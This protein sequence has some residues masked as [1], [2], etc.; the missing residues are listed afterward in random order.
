M[1]TGL[2]GKT[3]LITGASRNMGRL[4]AIEFA[5]E[6]ANL[7]LC[8]STKMKELAEVAEEARGLGAKVVAERCDVASEGDV[9]SFVDRTRKELG[10]V[11]V[12]INNAVNRGAEGSFA[13][14]PGVAGWHVARDRAGRG[15]FSV[16]AKGRASQA[17]RRVGLRERGRRARINHLLGC[18][19]Q[20]VTR[21]VFGL[22]LRQR[23]THE[24]GRIEVG[25][26]HGWQRQRRCARLAA[27]YV[28]TIGRE[29]RATE[30]LSRRREGTKGG[31]GRARTE[32]SHQQR[33]EREG[34]EASERAPQQ[35]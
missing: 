3:V 4:A 12:A 27:A 26:L 13:A 18:Y 28:V 14:H 11:H 5:R 24:Q 35:E 16:A 7:A 32:A 23:R 22:A 1:D 19:R 10:T 15:R 2:K 8:T 25:R 34:A 9:A 6:G 21:S 31:R 30:G 17:A 33:H 20:R 29:A